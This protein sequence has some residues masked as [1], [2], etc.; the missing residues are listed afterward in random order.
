MVI[1]DR[2][3]L[4][5][6]IAGH[7]GRDSVRVVRRTRRT[8]TLAGLLVGAPQQRPSANRRLQDFQQKPLSELE[9]GSFNARK[10]HYRVS[11]FSAT[12]ELVR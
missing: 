11:S 6:A 10:M 9:H 4:R 8:A 12:A 2:A 3:I 5:A 7:C 1:A